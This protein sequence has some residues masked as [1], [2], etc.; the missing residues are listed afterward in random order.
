MI[1]L[2]SLLK[3]LAYY[4]LSGKDPDEVYAHSNDEFA[5]LLSREI[6]DSFK[7]GDAK[8]LKEVYWDRGD[9][10]AEFEVRVR[11]IKRPKQDYSHSIEG[12]G[13]ADYLELRIE[14]NPKM[15][16]AEMNRLIAEIKETLV[17]ELEHVGQ[18]NFDDMF[19]VRG[20]DYGSPDNYLTSRVEIPAFVKG[21][22]KRAKVTKQS[23]DATM[24][25]WHEDNIRHFELHNT[26]WAAVKKVWMDWAKV[27]KD[28]IKKF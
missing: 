11:F 28:K 13:R 27:N 20:V 23:L 9:D 3:E 7:R 22:I 12:G 21:L 5:L 2:R 10:Y 1:R 18:Q 19:V 17:H 6:V 4:D 14:Y 26:N 15:F 8:Y 24:E 25:Q 16:P